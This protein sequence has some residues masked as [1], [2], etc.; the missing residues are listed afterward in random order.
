MRRR[1]RTKYTETQ[2]AL[3]W[4][5][6]KKGETLQSPTRL[7]EVAEQCNV[8]HMSMD[9]SVRAFE[10]AAEAEREA[11]ANAKD[12]L[13]GTP[14]YDPVAWEAWRAAV[15]ASDKARRAV[16]KSVGDD[17]RFG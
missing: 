12:K 3:M 8:M 7:Q 6:W 13:P 16:V 1:P 10:L 4:E 17:S 9:E 14:K 2:K 5:R 15:S 11:W